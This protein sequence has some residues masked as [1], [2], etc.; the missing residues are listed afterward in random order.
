MSKHTSALNV[1]TADIQ[2]L[3]DILE[4]GS[5]RSVDLIDRSLDQIEKHDHYLHTILSLPLRQSLE[6][7]ASK[8][9]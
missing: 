8:R 3:K 6:V 9:S 7:I 4:K 5:L 1:L 2:Y